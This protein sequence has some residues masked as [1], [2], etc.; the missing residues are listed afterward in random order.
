MIYTR[1]RD[2][3][4]EPVPPWQVLMVFSDVRVEVVVSGVDLS[5]RLCGTLVLFDGVGSFV[6]APG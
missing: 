4:S 5:A 3:C 2:D 6:L 1:R